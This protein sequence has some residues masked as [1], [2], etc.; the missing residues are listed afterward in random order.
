[1]KRFAQPLSQDAFTS[2]GTGYLREKPKRHSIV[3][4]CRSRIPLA[5]G[6][7]GKLQLVGGQGQAGSGGPG[8]LTSLHGMPPVSR[9]WKPG[10]RPD[11]LSLSPQSFSR[12]A[13]QVSTQ[14]VGARLLPRSRTRQTALIPFGENCRRSRVYCAADSSAMALGN[15]MLF[16]RCT[17]WCRSCSNSR[18][19]LKKL[20]KVGHAPTGGV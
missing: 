18:R 13:M 11:V 8:L 5:L 19:L 14:K 1:M 7:R 17:C 3:S 10:D 9:F 2:P 4:V 12:L 15:R 6:L 16:S 20:W